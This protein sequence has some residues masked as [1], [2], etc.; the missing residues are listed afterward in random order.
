MAE[1]NTAELIRFPEAK[2]RRDDM[3]RIRAKDGIERVTGR[4]RAMAVAKFRELADRLES[5][6]L[7]GAAVEWRR[8]DVLLDEYDSEHLRSKLIF[9]TVS[10]DTDW[11]AGTVSVTTIHIEES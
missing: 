8:G 4:S 7:D 10:A 11:K 2:T 1:P 9:S 3:P 6:E 5:G